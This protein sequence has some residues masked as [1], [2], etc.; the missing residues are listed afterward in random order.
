MEKNREFVE[1]RIRET[2]R[3]LWKLRKNK[4]ANAKSTCIWPHYVTHMY[5]HVKLI[6]YLGQPQP[7]VEYIHFREYIQWSL[8]I[9]V[10]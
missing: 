6:D 2:C 8:C 7:K 3:G 1:Y 5:I 4:N 9:H 10:H